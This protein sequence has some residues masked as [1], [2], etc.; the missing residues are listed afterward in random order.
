MAQ[1][2]RVNGEPMTEQE[3]L[4]CDDPQRMLSFLRERE[5]IAEPPRLDQATGKVA[6]LA[7]DRKLR[8]FACACCRAI[9]PQ[10]WPD[11]R[12]RRAVEV[13]ERFADGL[14][15]EEELDIARTRAYE[16]QA[17][18][19]TAG[20]CTPP[21]CC[22]VD[23]D[24]AAGNVIYTS[25]NQ[26]WGGAQASL[27]RHII[28][29]PFRPA[30]SRE[31]QDCEGTGDTWASSRD[32]TIGPTPIGPC[33]FCSSRGYLPRPRPDLPRHV[34]DLARVCYE[35]ASRRDKE[36]CPQCGLHWRYRVG[37]EEKSWCNNDHEWN[38]SDCVQPLYALADALAECGETEASYH[39]R[40]SSW[41]PRG[42]HWLDA[43]RET[44][45]VV[46]G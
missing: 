2:S 24:V 25:R 22:S 8:L 30:W 41:C 45:A 46:V 29:N 37:R 9:W 31:C 23:G 43:I 26:R 17:Q 3:W 1:I 35:G 16:V 33:E 34:E 21:H 14:A 38:G 5:W 12:S 36:H 44:A 28:G 15:T 10:L 19:A 11:P 40:A 7:T 18:A 27:L 42:C 20:R 39:F 6:L 32:G 4:A 13:A